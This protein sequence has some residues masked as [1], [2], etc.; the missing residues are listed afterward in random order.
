MF[1]AQECC[2]GR[3]L[4]FDVA[5]THPEDG[6]TISTA[7]EI[8]RNY[9]ILWKLYIYVTCLCVCARFKTTAGSVQQSPRFGLWCATGSAPVYLNRLVASLLVMQR[10]AQVVRPATHAR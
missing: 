1:W 10:L 3:V 9:D 5:Q 6:D 4:G 7:Q 2:P 8:R